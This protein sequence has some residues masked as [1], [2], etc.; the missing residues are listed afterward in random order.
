MTASVVQIAYYSEGYT[1]EFHGE[2]KQ[3]GCIDMYGSLSMDENCQ[4][5]SEE[6]FEEKIKKINPD[7]FIVHIFEPVFTPQWVYTYAERH[8]EKLKPVKA[9]MQGEQPILVIYQFNK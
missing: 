7:Y 5:V 9:Y 6:Q 4:K 2:K 3:E 8:P 1:Y